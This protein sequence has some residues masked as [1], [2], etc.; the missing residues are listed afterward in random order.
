MYVR[1]KLIRCKSMYNII[2]CISYLII[3]R[4]K[5]IINDCKLH[6][7]KYLCRANIYYGYKVLL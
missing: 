3:I 6:M 1:K 5:S 4:C 2:R 7:S